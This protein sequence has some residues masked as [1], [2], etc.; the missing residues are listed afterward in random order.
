MQTLFRNFTLMDREVINIENGIFTVTTTNDPETY[1]ALVSHVTGM[2]ARVEAQDDPQV[3]IQSPTLDVFFMRGTEID[4]EI[5]VTDDG[6][7]VT[8]TSTDPALV[9]ALQRHAAEVSDMVNRGMH[10]VHE[11]MMN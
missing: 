4:T 2:I 1:S 8:Q 10:A 11:R 3:I 9:S 7:A 6:I 5:E